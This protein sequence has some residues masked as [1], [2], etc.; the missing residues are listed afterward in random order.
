MALLAVQHKTCAVHN[1]QSGIP[2]NTKN[3]CA[4]VALLA[5]QPGHLCIYFTIMYVIKTTI[6]GRHRWSANHRRRNPHHQLLTAWNRLCHACR[7]HLCARHRQGQSPKR[8]EGQ[9]GGISWPVSNLLI[10]E[11]IDVVISEEAVQKGV[12]VK[13][14]RWKE[15]W[16]PPLGL[17]CDSL[18]HVRMVK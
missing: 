7:R 12:G 8:R 5:V 11:L 6:F 2:S 14:H 17:I 9:Q 13:T 4:I 1:A 15:L 3:L 10:L 16:I 18:E